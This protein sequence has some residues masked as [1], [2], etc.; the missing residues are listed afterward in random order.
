[1]AQLLSGFEQKIYISAWAKILQL[2]LKELTT[3]QSCL[4]THA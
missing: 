2:N 3:V 1:M 4:A